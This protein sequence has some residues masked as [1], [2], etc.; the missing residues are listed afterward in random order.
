MSILSESLKEVREPKQKPS[1]FKK[2]LDSLSEEDRK[3]ALDALHDKTILKTHLQEAFKRAGLQV[4]KDT[5]NRIRE[6]LQDGTL[7]DEDIQ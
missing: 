1:N 7:K 3:I 5:L 4:S 6:Q 2:W